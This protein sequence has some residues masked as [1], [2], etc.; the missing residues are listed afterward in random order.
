MQKFITQ[1]RR[2]VLVAF[3]N[4]PAREKSSFP[5]VGVTKPA[6]EKSIYL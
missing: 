3:D 6:Q 5:E 1:L 2:K 4:N